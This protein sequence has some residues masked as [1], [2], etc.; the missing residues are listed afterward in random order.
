MTNRKSKYSSNNAQL[1]HVNITVGDPDHIADLLTKLFDWEVRWSGASM[2]NG[3]TVH[4]GS[5]QSYIAL[6]TR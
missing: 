6:Y 5:D 3:Y 2:N 4:V 1:E